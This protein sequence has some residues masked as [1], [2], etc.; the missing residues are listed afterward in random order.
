MLLAITKTLLTPML[1]ALC[2]VVSHKWGDVV[3]GWLLGL[4][5]ASGPVS[6]FLFL[7]HGPGFAASAARFTLLGFVAV[8]VFCVSYL[9]M[10]RT[11]A[12]PTSS[13][14]AVVACLSATGALAFV[15]LS[16]SETIV[17]VALA[18]LVASA[19]MGRSDSPQPAASSSTGGLL[20]RMTLASALVL[21]ITASSGLLGGSVSGLLAPLPVL[22]ALMTASAHRR[23]GA[24]GVQGLLR[25]IV[26]G[27][28]GGVAFF[29]V[30]AVLVGEHAPL[31][32]YAA[33]FVAAVLAGWVATRVAST[34]PRLWLEEHVRH[35]S[36]RRVL[37]RLEYFGER[38]AFCDQQ[39]G[40]TVTALERPCRLPERAAA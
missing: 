7:Q 14:V 29:A 18:L 12:W 34:R 6:F 5:L 19:L 23:E 15:H 40:I 13:V 38:V 11:R 4:P 35:E 39:S 30:V 36:L 25:G 9:A 24:S 37:H 10:A 28:W 21:G 26:V 16:L 32:T 31:A 8:S 22:A 20:M 33:A 27:M 17:V 2:T 1:L 3:G